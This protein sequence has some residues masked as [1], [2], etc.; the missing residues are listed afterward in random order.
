MEIIWNPEKNK[1]LWETR[2]VCFEMVLDKIREL[3]FQGPEEN[4]A[5]KEQYRIIVILNDYPHVVPLIIDDSGNWFLKTIFP[6][7]KEKERFNHGEKK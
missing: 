3:D 6:S 4:P 2:K 7:R 5:R 1:T